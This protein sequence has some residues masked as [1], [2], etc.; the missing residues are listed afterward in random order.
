[1]VTLVQLGILLWNVGRLLFAMWDAMQGCPG[2]DEGQVV[3]S[4][5]NTLDVVFRFFIII[6]LSTAGCFN[7]IFH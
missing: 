7:R 5:S 1:M 4:W 3:Y 2:P 6:A